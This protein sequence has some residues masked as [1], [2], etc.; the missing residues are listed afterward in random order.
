MQ[1]SGMAAT[2]VESMPTLPQICRQVRFLHSPVKGTP[3]Y[4]MEGASSTYRSAVTHV[5]LP[6]VV[7][8]DGGTRGFTCP[9][10]SSTGP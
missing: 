3:C 7:G 4:P 9:M 6:L 1:N 10:G 5:G 8:E 2:V